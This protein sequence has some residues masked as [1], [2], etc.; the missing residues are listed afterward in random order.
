MGDVVGSRTRHRVATCGALLA[1]LLAWAP[2]PGCAASY[3]Y[4][5]YTPVHDHGGERAA[6]AAPRFPIGLVRWSDHDAAYVDVS[7]PQATAWG[8][9]GWWLGTSGT[10]LVF[11]SPVAYVEYRLPDGT[12]RWRALGPP[13]PGARYSVRLTSGRARVGGRSMPLYRVD[14]S[15]LP[16]PVASFPFPARRGDNA[17]L[18]ESY[19]T[20]GV[21]EPI[22]P[23]RY[24]SVSLYDGGRWR[25]WTPAVDEAV[26]AV[27]AGDHVQVERRW[28]R[29]SVSGHVRSAP[30]LPAARPILSP[31]PPAWRAAAGWRLEAPVPLEPP[32]SAVAVGDLG[33]DR[34]GRLLGTA[35]RADGTLALWRWSVPEEGTPEV[36]PLGDVRSRLGDGEGGWWVALGDGGAVY[37]AGRGAVW[38][39]AGAGVP[40]RADLGPGGTVAAAAA[41]GHGGMILARR[42]ERALSLWPAADALPRRL[43]LPGGLGTPSLLLA[44]GPRSWLAVETDG[45]TAQLELTPAGDLRARR[46]RP[47]VAPDLAQVLSRAPWGTAVAQGAD[48]TV[49]QGR[50]VPGGEVLM[51]RGV[52]AGTLRMRLPPLWVDEA[53]PRP[54]PARAG[55]ERI[56]AAPYEVHLAA[57]SGWVAAAPADQ[58]AVYIAVRALGAAVQRRG[59]VAYGAA[60]AGGA[61]AGDMAETAVSAKRAAVS[62]KEQMP[63]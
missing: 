44:D 61:P 33:A 57:G 26:I 29:W 32:A 38:L 41:F 16:G 55:E 5:G 50:P 7:N 1:A 51:G 13:P 11:R 15:F 4:G 28:H 8:Q 53:P 47:G 46:F 27:G 39:P 62:R 52:G 60:S 37:A 56:A 54:A 49:W 21:L 24:R 10:G 30:A 31:P 42:G 63:L 22:G 45:A 12:Y 40:R 58:P 48:G 59:G 43:A 19:S 18:A 2:A 14:V 20:G 3:R 25:R 6:I 17:G 34:R 35:F 23:A 36:W 9:A